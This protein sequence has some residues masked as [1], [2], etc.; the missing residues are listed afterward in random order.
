[1]I[2]SPLFENKVEGYDEDSLPPLGLGYIGTALRD[3]GVETRLIDAVADNIPVADIIAAVDQS[4]ANVLAINVFTT[5]LYLVRKIL[6][7]IHA[8]VRII[9]GGLST[10]TLW[11]DIF[12]FQ[13][14]SPID[15]VMGDGENITPALVNDQVAQLPE[16]A[17]ANRRY[18]KVDASSSYY[19]RDISAL[20]LD[21]SFFENEPGC[22]PINGETEVSIVTSRGCIYNCAFC[23]AARSQNVGMGIRERSGVSV[24]NE[25]RTLKER[26]SNL[27]SIRVLDDLFLKDPHSVDRAVEIFSNHGI[28]WRAMAHVMSFKNLSER[29][30]RELADSGCSELFIGIESGSPRILKRIHKTSDVA[31]IKSTVQRVLSVGISVKGYF[32]YGFPGETEED[33]QQT[34][35]L[36]AALKTMALNSKASF[37]TSVFRYRPY[38]GTELYHE[39]E[40]SGRALTVVPDVTVN[41]LIDR[42]QFNFYVENVATTSED[43]LYKYIVLTDALNNA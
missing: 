17:V 3:C 11:T 24:S 18:F 10:K 25:I 35:E 16:T 23:S 38:H 36:A 43:I 6:E 5:N 30:L 33:C 12:K 37:R 2:N 9:V 28:H 13:T 1:M 31:L 20:S 42:Q 34:Y 14:A 7:G 15:V 40:K 4:R 8:K 32:I 29:H 21:R 39:L 26:Y 27:S 41:R 22:N 19:Q